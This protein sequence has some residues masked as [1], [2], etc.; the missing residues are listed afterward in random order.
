VDLVAEY[1]VH[2]LAHGV[3]EP[4]LPFRVSNVY[5]KEATSPRPFEQGL[6]LRDM[7][8]FQ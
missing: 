7:C 4:I 2:I 8:L 3:Q 5:L 1:A 6:C